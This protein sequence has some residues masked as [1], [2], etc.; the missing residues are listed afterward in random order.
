[1]RLAH[2]VRVG[3][4]GGSASGKT[5]FADGLAGVLRGLGRGVV[6]AG[7]DGFHNPPEVRHRRGAMSVEGYVEDSFNY[8]AVRACVL[9]P[10]G[11]EGDLRYC[12]EV[13]DHHAGKVRDVPWVSAERDAILVFEGVM[14]FREELVD[15]FDYK[16][17]IETSP[18][19]ALER[20]RKRDLEHFGDVQTLESKYTQRFQPGQDLYRQQCRPEDLADL[21]VD[22]DD[23]GSPV[24]RV[25]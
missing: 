1:M 9:D 20:A 19:V 2:P 15:A 14:L 16:I 21:V 13:Y 25:G 17:L 10:L 24:V 12:A 5:Y 8:G 6:R 22:N 4:D 23:W 11:S 3:I 18:A 7:L